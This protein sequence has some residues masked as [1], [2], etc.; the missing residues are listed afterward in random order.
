MSN[1]KLIYKILSAFEAAMDAPMFDLEQLSATRLNVSEERRARYFEMLADCGYIKGVTVYADVTGDTAIEAENP[2][3]T[4]KG[5]EYL[6]ENG[7][8]QQL[9]KAAKSVKDLV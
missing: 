3:I 7:I 6:A 2:R 1:F 5:L 8:M 4:L 9:Y